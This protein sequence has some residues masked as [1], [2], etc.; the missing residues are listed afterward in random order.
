MGLH[1]MKYAAEKSLVDGGLGWTIIRPV[2]FVE[3]WMGVIGARLADQNKALVLGR[4]DNP[5]NMVP[6]RERRD[7]D[8]PRGKR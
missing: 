8:R 2:P 7:R 4:G 6:V 1:R 5:I 3:T